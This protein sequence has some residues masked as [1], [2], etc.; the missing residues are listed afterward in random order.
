MKITV[1]ITTDK[2]HKTHGTKCLS[3]TSR[4]P[5]AVLT[6]SVP[7]INK[8]HIAEFPNISTGGVSKYVYYPKNW[9]G[10]RP[11]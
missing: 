9:E 2:L 10:P 6:Y 3:A 11:V 5:N 7:G 1:K 8:I 4:G